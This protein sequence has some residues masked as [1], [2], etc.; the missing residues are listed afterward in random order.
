MD[1]VQRDSTTFI[2]SVYIN[3]NTNILTSIY[4]NAHCFFR[5]KKIA[6]AR[7]QIPNP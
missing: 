6:Q 5:A 4:K 2:C 3:F 7:I 1:A